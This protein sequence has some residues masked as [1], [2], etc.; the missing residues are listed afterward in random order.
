MA[1]K[2]LPEHPVLYGNICIFSYLNNECFIYL[3]RDKDKK[4]FGK[5]QIY[6]RLISLRNPHSLEIRLPKNQINKVE[7]EEEDVA[8]YDADG[9]QSDGLD[10]GTGKGGD[11]ME[12]G[13]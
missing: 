8:G 3:R 2:Q 4:N 12:G 5:A 1:R 7:G 6:E 10:T 9:V 13:V 11:V